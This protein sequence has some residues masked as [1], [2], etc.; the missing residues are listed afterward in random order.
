MK[1]IFS[2][3]VLLVCSNFSGADTSKYFM[4]TD[5]DGHKTFSQTQCPSTQSSQTKS[6]QKTNRA[7]DKQRDKN[8]DVSNL[9]SLN[10]SAKRRELERDIKILKRRIDKLY[11][12][13]QR[14]YDAI[15]SME[16]GVGSKIHAKDLVKNSSHLKH[17][18]IRNKYRKIVGEENRKMTSLQSQLSDIIRSKNKK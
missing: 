3:G 6:Y 15:P 10:S 5:N 18:K 17:E 2:I 11:S 1:K 9:N 16:V 7:N 14:A 8:K 4:C 13:E 12:D